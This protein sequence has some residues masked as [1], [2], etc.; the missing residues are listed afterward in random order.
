[1]K[2]SVEDI[3]E[4]LSKVKRMESALKMSLKIAF[5]VGL[6]WTVSIALV[7]MN[8]Y[9]LS[10]KELKLD[11]PVFVTWFQCVVTFVICL[12]LGHLAKL[13]P[14]RISFPEFS[15]TVKTIKDVLP[16]SVVFLAMIIF[17]N[18]C[19]KYVG[20]SFYFVG[21]SLTTVFNV[22]LTYLVLG[23]STSVP[24]LVCCG[25]IVAGFWLGVDQ[26]SVAGG[27]S[28][29][30]VFY[31]VSASI[32]VAMSA[33]LT[34]KALTA[35]DDC[36]WKL[37][38]YNNFLACILFVPLMILDQEVQELYNFPFLRSTQ[39]WTIMVITGFFGFAMGYVTGLQIKLTSPL[40]HNVSGTVKSCLQT[41]IAYVYYSEHKT[42][43]WWLSN[44]V[45]LA[46]SF[47]Y[48]LVRRKEML[49]PKLPAS[50]LDQLKAPSKL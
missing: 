33:I 29:Y 49:E 32:C 19:L 43:L 15:P 8:K 27:L 7:F 23:V 31:G 20:V 41:I 37:T 35:L 26:E 17:N 6:Y 30:G 12:I 45:L 48:T 25:F 38:M 24:A 9:L 39:F 3:E 18:L 50:P 44:F 28:W 40:T 36:V 16:L 34:K 22:L 13:F 14:N 5:A 21:R 10:S 42:L 11:A 47:A 2:E 46:A 4:G 1:M